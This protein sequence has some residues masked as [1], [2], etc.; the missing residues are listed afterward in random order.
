MH[1]FL[2]AGRVAAAASAGAASAVCASSTG[3][4]ETAATRDLSSRVAGRKGW[5]AFASAYGSAERCL[6][7]YV[8]AHERK[9]KLP[10]VGVL[11]QSVLH[12]L[13]F[14]EAHS[15]DRASADVADAIE[16]EPCRQFWPFA[17]A[18]NAPDGCPV[19]FCRLSRLNLPSIMGAF[20][21]ES[22]LHF[23][24]LWCEHCLR[25]QGASVRAD[26][27][28]K[29]VYDVYD[30]TG[31]KWS[32]LLVDAKNYR[33]ITSRVFA[34]GTLHYPETLYECHGAAL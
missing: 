6:T 2:R 16:A 22:T 30:C 24:A 5:D 34:T 17:F 8:R 14:R 26:G 4:D 28:C 23:F 1:C 7:A 25:L 27:G 3:C 10:E 11:E 13:A 29:G 21:E 9:G 32:Q 12:T 19:V 18:D 33:E 15:L 20:D 31:V